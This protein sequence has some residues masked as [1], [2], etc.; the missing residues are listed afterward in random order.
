MS[1]AIG[2]TAPTDGMVRPVMPSPP[3]NTPEPEGEEGLAPER[4]TT[5]TSLS[6]LIIGGV[7]WSIPTRPLCR[8]RAEA[9]VRIRSIPARRKS[10]RRPEAEAAPDR[11]GRDEQRPRE[12]LAIRTPERAETTPR[13]TAKKNVFTLT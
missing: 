11:L 9:P 8:Y 10:Q 1:D 5:S 6:N 7:G 4:K 12:I 2:G 13:V 3:I